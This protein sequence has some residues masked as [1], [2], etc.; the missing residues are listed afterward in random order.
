[1]RFLLISFVGILCLQCKSVVPK[2]THLPIAI[3]HRE[4]VNPYFIDPTF[5]YIYKITIKVFGNEMSGLLIIK[6]VAQDT[7]RIV[8]TSQFGTTF[9]DFELNREE[10]KV[11]TVI[12]ALDKRI[13]INTLMRDFTTLIQSKTEIKKAYTNG[14]EKVLKTVSSGQKNFYFYT[15]DQERLSQI[16]RSGLLGKQ[17]SID[18][19]TTENAKATAIKIKHHDIALTMDLKLIKN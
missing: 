13:I 1:M 2:S 3:E 14:V 10:Q 16:V 18:F 9:F 17:L 15:G 6:Q 11:H 19:N 5:D 7:H 8:C 4:L 12:A